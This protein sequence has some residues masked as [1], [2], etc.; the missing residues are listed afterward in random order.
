MNKSRRGQGWSNADHNEAR[1]K[2]KD[3][4][5]QRGNVQEFKR[6]QRPPYDP[7]KEKI[8]GLVGRLALNRDETTH[9]YVEFSSYDGGPRRMIMTKRSTDYSTGN[10]GRL[11]ARQARELAEL[12]LKGAEEL[13]AEESAH[14]R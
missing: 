14:Q 4:Y 12:L 5:E 3:G 1:R 2:D 7:S 13:E 8:V 10:V 11:W 9:V 6:A